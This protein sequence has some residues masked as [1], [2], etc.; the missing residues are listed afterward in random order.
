MN[1]IIC[2]LS[3]AVVLVS[4]VTQTI[5]VGNVLFSGGG[6]TTYGN[7]L[8]MQVDIPNDGKLYTLKSFG[9]YVNVSSAISGTFAFELF[10]GS[11]AAGPTGTAIA[12]ATVSSLAPTGQC[13]FAIFR[14]SDTWTVQSITA[15]P[16]PVLAYGV[17]F[18]SLAATPALTVGAGS[19]ANGDGNLFVWSNA[20]G[21][22][23]A[24]ASGSPPIDI[25]INADVDVTAPA[26][27]T[28]TANEQH[29]GYS[30]DYNF[31]LIVSGGGAP[32]VWISMDVLSVT[33]A[34]YY[35]LHSI[36][37]LNTGAAP[38]TTFKIAVYASANNK[39]TGAPLI[40]QDQVGMTDGVNRIQLSSITLLPNGAGRYFIMMS[41]S[42]TWELACSAN[43]GNGAFGLVG[44]TCL[45]DFTR[46]T[47]SLSAYSQQYAPQISG[48]VRTD[49][50]D[51][52]PTQVPYFT[53]AAPTTNP[54]GT[55]ATHGAT[56][57]APSVT[58]PGS[59]TTTPGGTTS[60]GGTTVPG[61]SSTATSPSGGTVPSSTSPSGS[62]VP[63]TGPPGS[64]TTPPSTTKGNSS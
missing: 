64:T 7:K 23:S 58:L 55:T 16:Q 11:V 60:P 29:V 31:T 33:N 49:S 32:G 4:G 14:G 24:A 34:Q 54:S 53:T 26:T 52:P 62:S 25:F 35:G 6:F 51:P 15:S 5:P 41:A 63:T 45:P 17:Y 36:E 21:N 3:L 47:N 42:D 2:L 22:W 57:P 37:V 48:Y 30:G 12:S 8:A 39:P 27:P 43:I 40:V 18:V 10:A 38:S 61:S 28:W 56:S 44:T 20:N 1:L 59:T 50:T 19:T 13:Q 46:Q 9:A